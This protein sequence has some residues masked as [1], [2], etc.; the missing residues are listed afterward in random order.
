MQIE[1]FLTFIPGLRYSKLSTRLSKSLLCFFI[2]ANNF[3]FSAIEANVRIAMSDLF[4][5]WT[6]HNNPRQE[7][8]ISDFIRTLKIKWP[9]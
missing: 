6:S 4:Y 3:I 1:S 5:F 9:F 7:L 2:L 8:P